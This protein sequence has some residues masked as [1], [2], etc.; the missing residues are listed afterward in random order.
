MTGAVLL[1][2]GA[3]M[4]PACRAMDA[5]LLDR[6]PAGDVVVVLGAPTPGAD[7]DRAARRAGSYY[8]A[9]TAR[10]VVVTAHPQQDL[11]ACVAALADAGAVVL[12]GGS[13]DRLHAGLDEDDAR[14]GGELLRLHQ[15]GVALSGASAGA[16][17]LC[18]RTVL[19]GRRGPAGP[20]VVDGLGLLPGLA[21]VHDDG[22]DARWADPGDPDGP[23]WGLP[24]AGGVLLVDGTVRAVGRG[25]TRLLL[26]GAQQHLGPTP[27]P[28]ADLLGP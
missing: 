6:A 13:P 24:E 5:D 8:G 3:E 9:L 4:Q 19:P 11:A 26:D 17:V 1:Q 28:L 7:H 21:L 20:A 18:A 15:E 23:R 27:R 10:R 2:G 12:P 25:R 14:L 16:M 22:G